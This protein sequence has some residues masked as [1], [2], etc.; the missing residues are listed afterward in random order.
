MLVQLLQ[1]DPI[2]LDDP[3]R[4]NKNGAK[5]LQTNKT[6]VNYEY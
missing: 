5:L 4:P 1:P 6:T 3:V 2:L